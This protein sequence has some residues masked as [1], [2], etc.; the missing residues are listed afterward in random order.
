[1]G[2]VA[3]LPGALG[4][5]WSSDLR[6]T[7]TMRMRTRVTVEYFRE[8]N[9]GAAKAWIPDASV[10]IFMNPGES[11][12]Y[13]RVLSSLFGITGEKG[14]LAIRGFDRDNARDREVGLRT[15]NRSGSGTFGMDVPPS[16]YYY[17]STSLSGTLFGLKNGSGFRTNFGG[18][19]FNLVGSGL[20]LRVTI[21][22]PV[23][24]RQ[25]IADL[26]VDGGYFQINDIFQVAGMADVET[27]Q[28]IA[29]V[30]GTNDDTSVRWAF[31]ASVN[32]NVTSDPSY[33]QKAW[34]YGDF[35]PDSP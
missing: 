16:T 30:G 19:P 11:V 23:S 5:L 17:G 34:G 2:G 1:M 26:R 8:G 31:Y 7:N 10:K 32:D 35:I 28:A 20:D 25:G 6:L 3:E 33:V 4:S 13:P 18:M 14:M 12:V 27:D 29:L 9:A 15:Y 22:D 21:Y 24:G